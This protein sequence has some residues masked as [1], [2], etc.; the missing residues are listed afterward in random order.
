M[1]TLAM[2]RSAAATPTAI[3]SSGSRLIRSLAGAAIALL[4]GVTSAQ[5]QKWTADVAS[6]STATLTTAP[7]GGS[8]VIK[9]NS[10][11]MYALPMDHAYAMN[12]AGL[13]VGDDDG[14]GAVYVN[15]Q[16]AYL[17]SPQGYTDVKAWAVSNNGIIVG[18]GMSAGHQRPLKW[19][20]YTSPGVDMGAIARITQP[21]AVNS[22]GVVAGYTMTSSNAAPRAYKWTPATGT[23]DIHPTG[24]DISTVYDVADSG[25]MSGYTNYGNNQ[26]YAARWYPSGAFGSIARGVGYRTLENGTVY[27]TGLTNEARMW[28]VSNTATLIGPSPTTHVVK[29]I[30]PNGRYVGVSY[31]GTAWTTMNGGAL[32]TL[33]VPAGTYGAAIDVSACGTILG[34][35]QANINDYH[36]VIWS[37]TTC[38]LGEIVIAQ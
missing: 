26:F 13:I 38:D 1:T 12:N 19:N 16:V 8:R 34:S 3:K 24:Y 37:K 32:V 20:S 23:V 25:F 17:A 27:G 21:L 9:F 36:P 31:S 33:P 10:Y 29:Q 28:D 18:T 11:S 15:G 6:A 30:S 5:A 35:Y 7:V 22:S 4:C 2:T 14:K